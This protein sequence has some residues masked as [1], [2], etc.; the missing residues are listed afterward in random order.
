MGRAELAAN[1]F[2]ITQTEERLQREG[3][4]GQPKAIET[5]HEIGKTVREA[6][7]EIR[8]TMPENLFR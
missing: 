8:G 6:I 4:I 2:R 7:E 1:D 3:A 5:H